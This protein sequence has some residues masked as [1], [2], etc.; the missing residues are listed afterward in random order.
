MTLARAL[1]EW[2]TPP[3]PAGIRPGA[4]R[5]GEAR[6]SLTAL[7]CRARA[8]L[9]CTGAGARVRRELALVDWLWEA[10]RMNVRRGRL[11]EM[12][13]VL[14]AGEA[15]CLGYARL[16]QLVGRDLGLDVGLAEVVVDN[17]GRAVPHV[18]NIVKM[19]DGRIR[20]I[21]LWYGSRNIRHRRLGLMARRGGRWRVV[22]MDW[23]DLPRWEEVKGLPPR[24]VEAIAGYMTGNRHLE[25][26]I[27]LGDAGELREAVRRYGAAIELC[28][29][30]SRVYFNRA[31]ACELLGD[32]RTAEADYAVALRDEAS[33]IRVQARQHDEVVR[34]MLLDRMGASE[35]DQEI[36]LRQAGFVTG[37]EVPPERVAA[38]CRV[39]A[40]E[41]DEVLRRIRGSLRPVVRLDSVLGLDHPVLSSE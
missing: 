3:L 35:R 28:P 10:I 41:V 29:H 12:E 8:W 15:D 6:P 36:Y 7:G 13:S 24:C 21:D 23:R 19:A 39:S 27:S 22:D 14:G 38:S 34:L 37:R 4:S 9:R 5:H 32:R 1:R 16:F 18:V 31:V 25:R 20:F 40:R 33:L 2:R 11:F 30:N 17:A 26:G